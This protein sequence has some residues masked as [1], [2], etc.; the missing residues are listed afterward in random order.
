MATATA[1]TLKNYILYIIH[2]KNDVPLRQ[3]MNL[4]HT[5]D[6]SASAPPLQN[7]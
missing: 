5:S 7:T 1:P 3:N 4:P 2:R 6:A